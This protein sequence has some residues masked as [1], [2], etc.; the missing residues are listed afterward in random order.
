VLESPIKQIGLFICIVF[1][2]RVIEY[3]NLVQ[4]DFLKN[5]KYIIGFTKTLYDYMPFIIDL[6]KMLVFRQSDTRIY[7]FIVELGV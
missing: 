7:L 2:C 3:A 6:T 4:Q 1:Q 5:L